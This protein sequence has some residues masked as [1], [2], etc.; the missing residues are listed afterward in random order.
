MNTDRILTITGVLLAIIAVFVPLVW[1]PLI[2]VVVGLVG[3]FATPLPD[4]ASRAAY[5]VAAFAIPE[6]AN[7]L[8]AIPVAGTYLNHIF[9]NFAIVIAGVVLANIVLLIGNRVMGDATN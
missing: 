8:D 5:L 2:L 9:D 4:T 3:G 7:T 1:W 6:I